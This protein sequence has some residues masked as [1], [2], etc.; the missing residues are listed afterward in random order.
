MTERESG[1]PSEITNAPS[2]VSHAEAIGAKLLLL[3]GY[4][5]ITVTT[6]VPD[7]PRAEYYG[8]FRGDERP[9][10]G[11]IGDAALSI[12][13]HDNAPSFV[14]VKDK[15]TGEPVAELT[16]DQIEDVGVDHPHGISMPLHGESLMAVAL[17]R[18]HGEALL[19][20]PDH[21]IEFGRH[22]R[23]ERAPH[24]EH[25][26]ITVVKCFAA[27]DE[28]I[29]NN[30]PR[31]IPTLEEAK[32]KDTT[33]RTFLLSRVDPET[34]VVTSRMGYKQTT[35]V[36]VRRPKNPDNPPLP[37]LHIEMLDMEKDTTDEDLTATHIRRYQGAS[38]DYFGAP[39]GV[40]TPLEAD[41][42]FLYMV[43]D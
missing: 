22:D 20:W 18:K 19:R 11:Q 14:A 16:F 24:P 10:L 37:L 29:M 28:N 4:G 40:M 5:P 43:S 21:V 30:G 9:P 8:P 23:I 35:P 25:A 13:F 3:A 2:A 41:Q 6:R 7:I 39:S 36:L 1:A 33:P 15:H 42:V 12:V 38:G 31:K 27:D 17:T 34:Y 26:G 32:T